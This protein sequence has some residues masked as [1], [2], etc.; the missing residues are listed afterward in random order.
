MEGRTIVG[1]SYR[2]GG[3]PAGKRPGRSLGVGCVSGGGAEEIDGAQ[4]KDFLCGDVA[5][6]KGG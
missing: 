6:R 3:C 5:S 2:A 1:F 4:S